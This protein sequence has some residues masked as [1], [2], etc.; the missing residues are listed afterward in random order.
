VSVI[1][2]ACEPRRLL[3]CHVRCSGR[4]NNNP[5]TI[6]VPTFR[7]SRSQ[8]YSKRLPS[9]PRWR[10]PRVLQKLSDQI[11]YYYERAGESRAMA[12]DCS[13]QR[14]RKEH[15]ERERRW[16]VLAASYELSERIGDFSDELRR[17]LHVLIPPSPPH[18][19]ISLIRCSEC[20][21]R[22]RLAQLEPCLPV[23]RS[24]DTWTFACECGFSC[25]R[26]VDRAHPLS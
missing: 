5:V 16:L 14:D 23:D 6:D 25:E 19:A 9:S 13:N 10:G 3:G 18:P 22:M 8:S 7:S 11:A 24:A 21:K 1:R 20:G 12:A 15:L 2:I 17:Q 4:N 26:V